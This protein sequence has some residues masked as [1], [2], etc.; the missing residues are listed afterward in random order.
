MSEA[1]NITTFY[2]KR[3]NNG[4]LELMT[5]DEIN[6]KCQHQ[7]IDCACDVGDRRNRTKELNR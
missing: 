7:C 2:C 1:D 5:Q 4:Y 6:S 3:Q